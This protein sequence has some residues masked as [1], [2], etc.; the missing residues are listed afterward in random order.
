M[1]FFLIALTPNKTCLSLNNDLASFNASIA[2]GLS[3]LPNKA[4]STAS[5]K[6]LSYSCLIAIT[7]FLSV[8]FLA[9]STNP[10][11]FFLKVSKS[12]SVDLLTATT[13]CGAYLL[14]KFLTNCIP[15]IVAGVNSLSIT[16]VPSTIA[17]SIDDG[18]TLILLL[19]ALK[20]ASLSTTL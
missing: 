18:N 13:G 5:S 12:F 3:P 8:G 4:L 9:A 1:P 16:A 10:L 6:N 20:I 19:L 11:I 2:A 14:T 7:F 17:F 15:L